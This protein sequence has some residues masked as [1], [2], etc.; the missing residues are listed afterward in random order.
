MC[1]KEGLLG[2]LFAGLMGGDD[3]PPPVVASSVKADADK[4]AADAASAGIQQRSARK[5]AMR[6][7]SLLATGAGGDESNVVTGLPA[8]TATKTTLGA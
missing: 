1:G 7:Q 5:R 8:A 4:A 3:S 6:A 2:G